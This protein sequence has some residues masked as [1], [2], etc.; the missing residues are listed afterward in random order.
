M[1]PRHGV[2]WWDRPGAAPLFATRTN[3]ARYSEGP[4]VSVI[5]RELGTPFLPWQDYAADVIGERRPDGEYEYQVVVVSVPRQSGKTTLLRAVGT[6]RCL[7][8]G[9]DV[10]YTAQTG[11]D[12]RERWGDL[13]K[14]LETS[15]A[16]K[17]RVTVRR[18]AGQERVVFPG[19]PS[20]RAFAPTPESLHGYTPPTVMVDE[21]FAQTQRS[22]EL[23]MGAIGPAQ[24]TVVDKQILIVS[25][26]GTAESAFL[27]EWVARGMAG[28][29]RV[30][31]VLWAATDD[32]D[33]FTADTIRA[34][35]PA[36]GFELNGKRMTA[37]DILRE[38]GNNTRAE[39]ERA[40]LNRATL[41]SS[42]TVPAELWRPLARAQVDNPG[43]DV[44]VLS[45]AVSH[46]SASAS[47][48]ASWRVDGKPHHKVVMQAPGASWLPG[49][50]CELIERG[51]WRAVAALGKP[52][53]R[54]AT[55]AI[56]RAGHDVVELSPAEFADATDAMLTD[57]ESQRM[58]HDGSAQLAN[59]FAGVATK[60]S[61]DGG[62]VFSQA[63]SVG[64][65]S[66]AIA[67][68]VG[69]WVLAHPPRTAP[70]VIVRV[71]SGG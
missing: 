53:T 42:H 34:I 32:Q 26:M 3:P 31:L 45:Y 1:T 67:A 5:A 62:R 40:Y 69:G 37:D 55:D 14:A 4:Q 27:A 25:T 52:P 64:D 24:V 66:P 28:E 20:F 35:H 50:V 38:A 70:R 44:M 19:G 47:I 18:A 23:L 17:R 58:T 12:A 48:V 46:N 49:A 51:S 59:A 6:H 29:P 57:I 65:S 43:T 7:V 39:Y 21:A 9:R 41:T 60:P 36:V 54:A 33:P 71:A 10:F 30:A 13:V 68:T 63:L 11:K 56:K 61:G 8:N 15:P 22:G 16:L 2:D